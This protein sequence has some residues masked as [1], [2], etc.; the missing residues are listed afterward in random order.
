VLEELAGG[1]PP[2]ELLAGEEVIVDAV[3]LAHARR[4]RGGGD[5]QLQVAHAIHHAADQRALA[6]ARWARDDERS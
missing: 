1:N 2:V 5:R 3:D 6:H 4:A